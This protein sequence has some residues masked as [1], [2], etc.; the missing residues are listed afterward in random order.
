MHGRNLKLCI[1]RFKF[2]PPVC[3]SRSRMRNRKNSRRRRDAREK[4]E[5]EHYQIQICSPGMCITKPDAELE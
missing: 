1:I 4:F 2:A 5:A 3:A